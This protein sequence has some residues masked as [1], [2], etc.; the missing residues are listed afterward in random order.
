M[1]P[2]AVHLALPSVLLC[3]CNPREVSTLSVDKISS[4]S[5][6]DDPACH[7][8]CD[9]RECLLLQEGIYSSATTAEVAD[10]NALLYRIQC[11]L[12]LCSWNDGLVVLV[13]VSST[14]FLFIQSMHTF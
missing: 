4:R 14:L 9:T 7:F 1:S 10:E 5:M 8:V 2:Q 12:G 3:C 13:P 6:Y 11:H